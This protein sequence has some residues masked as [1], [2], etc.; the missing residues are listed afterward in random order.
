MSEPYIPGQSGSTGFAANYP[1]DVTAGMFGGV[2]LGPDIDRTR[3]HYYTPVSATYDPETNRTRVQFQPIP[4]DTTPNT[5]PVE[6]MPGLTR[7]QIRQYQREMKK[8]Q[9]GRK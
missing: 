8:L 7:Q 4:K 1:G 2:R 9:K 5:M 3:R 6:D